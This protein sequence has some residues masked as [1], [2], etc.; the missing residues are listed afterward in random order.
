MI[1]IC[2]ALH[3]AVSVIH[4][5]LICW[6]WAGPFGAGDCQSDST[7]NW[8]CFD[9]QALLPLAF[10]LHYAIKEK[11]ILLACR[12]YLGFLICFCCTAM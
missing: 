2:I 5:C 3:P 1:L 10:W 8:L 7:L 11:K 9:L 6:Q 12:V 4:P